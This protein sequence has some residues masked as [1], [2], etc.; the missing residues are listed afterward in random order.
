MALTPLRWIAAALAGCLAMSVLILNTDLSWRQGSEGE[1]ALRRVIDRHGAHASQTAR[2]LRL[3]VQLDSL[4]IGGA[5]TADAL[6]TPPLPR[7]RVRRDA[8]MPAALMARLDRLADRAIRLA[9]DSNGTG[10]DIVF[11]YDTLSTMRGASVRRGGTSTD[12]VLPRAAGE[13]CTVLVHVEQ[14]GDTPRNRAGTFATESAA[15]QLLGP[16]AYYRAFGI[17]GA[18]VEAWLRERGWMFVGDGSWHEATPPYQF[19]NTGYWGPTFGFG[20]ASLGATSVPVL[21]E[22]NM[23]GARCAWGQAA[24]C[25][26]VL[27]TRQRRLPAV[28]DGNVLFYSYP[29]LNRGDEW[30]GSRPFGRRERHLLADMVRTLGRERFARFWSSSEPVPAAFAQVAGEP[31]DAWATRWTS[32][33]YG[34]A[35]ARGAG[36]GWWA[37]LMSVALIALT[38]LVALRASERRQFA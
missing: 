4:G 36:M 18:R 2:V 34:S 15:R 27:L 7:T 24:A 32:E 9:P 38:L 35:P 20:G 1:W 5:R 30:Y 25:D 26:R 17:P 14:E 28:I 3:A 16:C 10:T 22:M 11:L 8:A 13:R 31:L 29:F 6:A 12:Y 19:A 23:D 33:Q 21:L 37:G